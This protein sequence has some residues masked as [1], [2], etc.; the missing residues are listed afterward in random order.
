[1]YYI[2]LVHLLAFNIQCIISELCVIIFLVLP[3]LE[4]G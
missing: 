3:V 1:M 2:Q 4:I